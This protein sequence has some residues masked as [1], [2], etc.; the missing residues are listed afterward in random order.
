[1]LFLFYISFTEW[2]LIDNASPI[3]SRL[4]NYIDLLGDVNFRHS[5]R[6]TVIFTVISLVIEVVLGVLIALLFNNKFKG[7]TVMRSF[8][9]IPMMSTAAVMGLT[10][11]ILYNPQFGIINYILSLFNIN[12]PIWLGNPKLALFSLILVDVWEWTPFMA[13]SSLAALQ[14]VPKEPIESAKIDG[15]DSFSLFRYIILPMILPV[16]LIAA[17]F[18]LGSLLRW[19][20][21]FYTMTAGGPG[22]AT[23]NLGMYLWRT[24]FYYFNLSYAAA[25]SV[26]LIVLTIFVTYGFVKASRMDQPKEV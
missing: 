6:L 11:R 24:G 23:E 17:S 16:I 1:M 18:R 25:G 20:D 3:F 8:L 21:T 19:F 9:L 2:N 13:L 14:I 12:G 26:I 10:W 5:L 7:W 22:R 4:K 15:A